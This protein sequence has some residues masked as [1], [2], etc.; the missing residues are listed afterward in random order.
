MFVTLEVTGEP[1]GVGAGNLTWLSLKA[2]SAL[3]WLSHL[4]TPRFIYSLVLLYM[5][6]SVG[7]STNVLRGHKR[8]TDPLTLELPS[9]VSYLIW[10]LGTEL[11]S[12]LQPEQNPFWG[13]APG[14]CSPSG[15]TMALTPKAAFLRKL[16]GITHVEA[17]S[18]SS[19]RCSL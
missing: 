6:V 3:E 2:A 9:V 14:T 10:V 19:Y 13:A 7:V 16:L 15:L 17:A 11:R 8:K 12:S 1:P 5:C 18:A 4:L